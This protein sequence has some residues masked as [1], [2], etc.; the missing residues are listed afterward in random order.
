MSL[1][2][3]RSV[4]A[5]QPKI[6]VRDASPV[7]YYASGQ[8]VVVSAAA[9]GTRLRVGV[10]NSSPDHLALTQGEFG[11][12]EGV[13]WVQCRFRD[14]PAQILLGQID[15]GVWHRIDAPISPELAGLVVRARKLDGKSMSESE[16][17][18][19]CYRDGASDIE[20]VIDMVDVERV[21]ATQDEVMAMDR[22]D[23]IQT[24]LWAP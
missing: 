8:V 13:E 7:A 19:C 10:D 16:T 23:V 11:D 22:M 20:A 3:A 18:A 24:R 2:A 17:A 14:V 1:A 21:R 4:Q 15:A 9:G 6:A 12:V 5:I